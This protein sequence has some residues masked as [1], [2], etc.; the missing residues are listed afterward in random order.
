MKKPIAF[1]LKTSRSNKNAA[2][3]AA[4]AHRRKSLAV[5][6]EFADSARSQWS[7]ELK[8]DHV[9]RLFLMLYVAE[10]IRKDRGS[11]G[12][13]NSD[14]DIVLF[15]FRM[16]KRINIH[17]KPVRIDLN[18]TET[19]DADDARRFWTKTLRANED[20]HVHL[21]K[22]YGSLK[23]RNWVSRYGIVRLRI[24]DTYVKTMVDVWI[25]LFKQD[26]LAKTA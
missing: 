8:D 6:N 23:G 17:H 4:Q 5:H 24:Y 7:E 21:R 13:T 3:K 2:L 20:I 18:L 25:D 9:F 16:M 15:A 12:I 10:G 1:L 19:F 14:P 11:F 22:E 26:I